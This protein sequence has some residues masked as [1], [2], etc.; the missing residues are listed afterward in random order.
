MFSTKP[1]LD[2]RYLGRDLRAG[3]VVFLVAIPLCLGIAI[4][5]GAPPV[6]A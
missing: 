5:P 6:S 3:M 2:T 1:L 4:A